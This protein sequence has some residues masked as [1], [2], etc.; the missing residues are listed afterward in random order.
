MPP[1]SSGPPAGDALAAAIRHYQA[2]RLEQSEALLRR[3]LQRPAPPAD[4]TLLLAQVLIDR[5]KPEQ[6]AFELERTIRSRPGE[7][8]PRLMLGKVHMAAA[9]YARALAVLEDAARTHPDSHELCTSLGTV[10]VQLGR[11]QEA[12]RWL[13]RALELEPADGT[14]LIWLAQ[15]LSGT[16]RVK[17]AVDLLRADIRARP[18][19]SGVQQTL[20]FLLQYHDGASP[21]E[22]LREH[23]LAGLL[24]ARLADRLPPRVVVD[25]D[26][27]RR[28]TVGYISPD[29]RQHSCSYFIEPLLAAHDRER[30]RIIA[31]SSTSGRDAVTARLRGL[32]DE[33]R[34]VRTLS[35]DALA[36]Q[37]AADRADIAVDLAGHSGSTRLA[38]LAYRPAPI[39]M[40]YL[41]Y[42]NTTGMAGIDYRIVDPLT[43]PLGAEAQS[44]EELIRLDPCFL[45]YRPPAD[46]PAAAP[47]PCS[48]GGPVTF[49]SFNAIDKTSPA[50]A[51]AWAR[52]LAATPG[53]RLLLKGSKLADPVVRGRLLELLGRH[54]IDG[55]R[56]DLLIW[57]SGV[58]EHLEC[59]GRMDIALDPFPYNGTTTTCEALWMGVPVVTVVGNMHAGRV[60]ASLLSAVGTP[61]LVAAG[62]DDYIRIAIELAADRPRLE[63]MRSSL[64]ERMAASPLCDARGHAARVEAEYRRVWRRWCEGKSR[65]A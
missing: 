37:I 2:G 6:A 7:L 23:K 50:A 21:E 44:T 9:E 48:V 12:E 30:F 54:G 25:A 55:S 60:G 14:A 20:V 53:S 47:P 51:A 3:L 45:C 27:E 49:G 13:R 39:A 57:T 42:P 33:W 41:G 46:A 24:V 63:A 15:T 58:R 28:L 62:V 5:Q 18:G 17:E 32:A 34:E 38:A 4:A 8:P 10:C 26:P 61:E 36:A 16:L 31:Y 52:I 59:Y 1:S 35:D 29:F 40:T 11:L 64:R 56:V 19:R 65:K 22:V 43:D